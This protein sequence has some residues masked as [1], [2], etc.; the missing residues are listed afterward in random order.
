[1]NEFTTDRKQLLAFLASFGKDLEDLNIRI[2]EDEIEAV[3]GQMTH[4]LRARLSVTDGTQGGVTISDLKRLVTFLKACSSE[5]ATIAQAAGGKTLH[6]TCGNSKLQLPSSTYVRS[7]REVGLIER[8]V[9]K[10]QDGMWTKWVNFPLNYSALVATAHFAPV[11]QMV[12]VIGDKLSCRTEF[13]A[14][15]GELAIR[16]GKGT[17]GKMFVRI[18]LTDATGPNNSANST[19]GYW[20]PSLLTCLPEGDITIHTGEDTVMVFQ[21]E[22]S[23]FLLIV[24]D[25]DYEED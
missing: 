20:L 4:Y 21:Q 9:Q 23:G 6:V 24:M 3:I 15:D 11:T 18:P 25:Q 16:A 5:Y 8:L 22:S 19:F 10:A 1:M 17:Q 7:Q 12:K 2:S 14:D 13:S